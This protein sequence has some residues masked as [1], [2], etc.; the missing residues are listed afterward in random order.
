[1]SPLDQNNPNSTAEEEIRSFRLVKWK[2]LRATSGDKF[3]NLLEREENRSTFDEDYIMAVAD[4]WRELQR[5]RYRFSALLFFLILLMGAINTEEIQHIS[6]LGMSISGDSPALEILLLLTSFLMFFV[7]IVSLT[8]DSYEDM[9]KSHIAVTKS[10]EISKYYL[11]RFGWSAA[12]FL[13]ETRGYSYP[14]PANLALLLTVILIAGCIIV[15]GSLAGILQ[16]YL[17]ISSIISAQAS[18][19]LPDLLNVP[20]VVV[21]ICAVSFNVGAVV[22]AVPLPYWDYSNLDKLEELEKKEPQRAKTIRENIARDDLEKERRNIRALQLIVV[23]AFA[24]LPKIALAGEE[25]FADYRMLAPL[26]ITPLI[27]SVVVAPVLDE[28]QR[29]SLLVRCADDNLPVTEYVRWKRGILWK[30]LGACCVVG[31]ALFIGYEYGI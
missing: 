16:Y 19:Q 18:A 14:F 4:R 9:I 13:G 20:I 21:A 8:S 31:I 5:T 25:F 26:L 10:E 11:L 24:I 29:R 7:A 17:F 15:A 6:F 22:V 28:Y 23:M 12:L 2:T 3:R 1:M 30:R 27:V